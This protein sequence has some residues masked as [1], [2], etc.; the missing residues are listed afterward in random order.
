MIFEKENNLFEEWINEHNNNGEPDFCCDGLFY[1]K[2]FSQDE[3]LSIAKR[4][5]VFF[6][7]EPNN[8]PNQ[9][10]RN[11]FNEIEPKGVFF[12]F[13]LSWLKT[14]SKV[15]VNDSNIMPLVPQ[16]FP[17]DLPLILVNAKKTSGGTAANDEEVYNYANT[18]RKFIRRQMDIYSPNII[19]C[20]GGSVQLDEK[21]Q[22][23]IVLMQKIIMCLIYPEIEFEP[24]ENNYIWYSA[25]KKMVLINS[26]HPSSRKA[27][28]EKYNEL[29]ESFRDF[30]KLNVF[31]L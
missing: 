26:W 5:I 19:L 12:K 2:N 1:N 7:K 10:Y 3:L 21:R 4:K 9:D 24:M 28:E 15:S 27:K 22:K 23:R 20:G 18:Y 8:Q 11:W 29:I 17:Q 14:L 30:I 6:M 25:E 31:D 13:I 16:I